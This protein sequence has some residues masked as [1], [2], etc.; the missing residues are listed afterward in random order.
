[1]N[2]P[3]GSGTLT[4]TFIQMAQSYYIPVAGPAFL[5]LQKPLVFFDLETTGTDIATDRIVEIYAIKLHTDGSREEIYHLLNPA[6]PIAP[7]AT[8]KHGFTNELVADK[9]RFADVADTLVAFFSGCDLAG[10]NIKKFDVPVL[11]EEFHRCRK[12]PIQLSEVKLIDVL[13]IYHSKE[14]RDLA[15]AVRFYC[16]REHEQA[17]SARADVLATIDIL[18]QQLLRYEDLE[19]NT[20]FLHDYTSTGNRVDFHGKF[21]RNGEGKI[22]FHFGKHKGK[23]AC[24]EP[25]YLEW[26]LEQDFPIDTKMVAKR[27]FKNSIWEKEI[28]AWLEA[29]KVLSYKPIASALYAAVKFEKAI[30]PFTTTSQEHQLTITYLTE[31]PSSYTLVHRDAVEILLNMLDNY[32]SQ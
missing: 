22:V 20:S 24:S 9:P 12:Y 6:I 1:M 17:H 32:L 19:P 30:F 29:N 16:E 27:I 2:G 18:K 5:K 15:A 25:A 10:Y 31:P 4:L 7:G 26:M 23:E 8:A 13:S 3:T 21:I 11:M 14:K 28:K